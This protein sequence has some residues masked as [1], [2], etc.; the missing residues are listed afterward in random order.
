MKSACL[1]KN[2]WIQ[3]IHLL[4][5]T[6]PMYG[7]NLTLMLRIVGF[8]VKAKKNSGEGRRAIAENAQA[9]NSQCSGY[10]CTDPTAFNYSNLAIVNDGT[11]CYVD[12]VPTLQR[13]TTIHQL[14]LIM[15]LVFRQ[16]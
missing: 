4:E 2:I 12:G 13:V 5:Q 16:F 14:V 7:Y 6:T 11:C 1:V 8:S 9:I 15:G 3:F 10:G